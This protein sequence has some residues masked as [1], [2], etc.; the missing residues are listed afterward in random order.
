MNLE[1]QHAMDELR[2]ENTSLR[3]RMAELE[4]RL[5]A[6]RGA[7]SN[8]SVTR[9]FRLVKEKK[10]QLETVLE[11][12]ER[13]L[14]E[15]SRQNAII[16]EMR[17]KVDRL[18]H[19]GNFYKQVYEEIP[20]A[21][22]C[23]DLSGRVLL[24]NVVA[25]GLFGDKSPLRGQSLGEFELKG[26]KVDLRAVFNSA[27]A[28]HTGG[29]ERPAPQRLSVGSHKYVLETRLLTGQERLLGILLILTPLPA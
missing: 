6:I 9:M 24:S 21:L 27:V 16:D 19:L 11:E 23:L 17:E 12:N 8:E 26:A 29:K 28:A 4:E 1:E 3:A 5:D 14:T 13:L 22:I 20:S 2:S 15:K 10:D 18:S 25:D 7:T